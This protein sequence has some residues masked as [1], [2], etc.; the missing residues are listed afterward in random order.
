MRVK[1][2]MLLLRFI[3]LLIIQQIVLAQNKAHALLLE[4]YV[5]HQLLIVKL[6]DISL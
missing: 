2:A 6:L 3:L 1:F 5:K 4:I